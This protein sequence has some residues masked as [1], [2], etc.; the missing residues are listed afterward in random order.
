LRSVMWWMMIWCWPFLSI[1]SCILCSLT[2]HITLHSFFFLFC[3]LC[4]FEGVWLC[5]LGISMCCLS[6]FPYPMT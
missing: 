1:S 6:W 4:M 2:A 5:P 3:L